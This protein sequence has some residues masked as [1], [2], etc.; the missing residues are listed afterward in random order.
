MDL[1]NTIKKDREYW[2]VDQVK[3]ESV[4]DQEYIEAFS[5]LLDEW[6]EKQIGYL[7]LLMDARYEQWLLDQGFRK[8]STIV[9]YTRALDELFTV[10]PEIAVEALEDSEMADLEFAELYEQC[11]SG[12]ANKNKLFTI[13]QV[14]ESLENEIGP[15]WRASCFIFTKLGEP[16]GLSIPVIEQGT[17]D[18]GRLFISA[19]CRNGEEKDMGLRFIGVHFIC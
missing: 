12:S 8:V 17:V 18:E 11:R 13:E 19:S 10:D 6:R 7:S 16:I 5:S 2:L 4:L 15:E 9:E 3:D 14:M 1:F